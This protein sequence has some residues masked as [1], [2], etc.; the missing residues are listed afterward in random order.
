MDS[1]K[2]EVEDIQVQGFPTLKFIKSGTN[3]VGLLKL[4]A[5]CFMPLVG[6]TRLYQQ[7]Q[8]TLVIYLFISEVLCSLYYHFTLFCG[9]VLD[10][11]GGRTLDDLIEFVEKTVSGEM[12]D[13]EDDESGEDDTDEPA[14]EIKKDE[15]QN[16]FIG[17]QP[18]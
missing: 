8:T 12:A 4:Y 10:Y 5:V 18:S 17:V 6:N 9:Q 16:M 11:N 14:E 13:D 1:T 15:L 2:N 3:E 7:K